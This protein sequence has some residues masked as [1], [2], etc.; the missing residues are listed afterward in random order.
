VSFNDPDPKS[1]SWFVVGGL[2]GAALVTFFWL[3][4]PPLWATAATL[5][6]GYEGWTFFNRYKHDTLSE[7]VWVLV[8]RPLVP[9]LFGAGTVALIA[10]GI[11]K[12]NIEGLYV[13]LSV[14][15]LMGHFVF[16]RADD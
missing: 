13:A 8:R 12:P 6:L 2:L 1:P 7:V 4:L 10:H 11:I 5:L 14:G 3:V 9:F 16:Q 15:V